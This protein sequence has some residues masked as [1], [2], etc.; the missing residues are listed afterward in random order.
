GLEQRL[1]FA[2]G[3]EPPQVVR[4]ADE[5]TF[6]EHHRESGPS[7]PHLERVPASPFAEIAAVFEIDVRDVRG[8]ER[9]A[10]LTR[11]RVLLH[12]YDHHVVLGDRG[13]DFT[14]DVDVVGC[15]LVADR[16]MDMRNI[17]D[18]TAHG[19]P[20]WACATMRSQ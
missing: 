20:E 4:P 19:S 18:V 3:D 14:H 12:A 13:L 1:D 2:A 7:G 11:S 8:G 15:D 9:L 17:Q 6:H 10:R 16:R 5:Y